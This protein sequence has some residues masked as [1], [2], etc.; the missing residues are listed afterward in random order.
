M[1]FELRASGLLAG[2]FTARA[3]TPPVLFCDVFFQDRFYALFACAG[4][5]P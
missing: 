1:G 3:T 2:A 4:F 5:E